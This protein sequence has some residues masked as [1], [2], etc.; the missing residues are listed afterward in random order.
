MRTVN[1]FALAVAA[2]LVATACSQPFPRFDDSDTECFVSRD[3]GDVN[4]CTLGNEDQTVV[5]A[6]I[7]N[8]T[9]VTSREGHEL[10]SLSDLVDVVCYDPDTDRVGIVGKFDQLPDN[11]ETERWV[12]GTIN[13]NV[14]RDLPPVSY[15]DADS[16]LDPTGA[17]QALQAS[18]ETRFGSSETNCELTYLTVATET[19]QKLQHNY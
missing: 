3:E 9:V 18:L 13:D 8:G 17:I 2:S 16:L 11:R 10:Y 4:V 14:E 5:S 19:Q 6:E 12:I 1:I 7:M 15:V